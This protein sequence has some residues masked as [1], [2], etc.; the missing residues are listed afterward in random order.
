MSIKNVG[1]NQFWSL[2]GPKRIGIQKLSVQ[3]NI[4]TNVT[5]N[6]T[7]IQVP[8]K[9]GS[10][11]FGSIKFWVKRNLRNNCHQEKFCM[12]KCLCDSSPD[13]LFLGVKSVCQ[14]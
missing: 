4:E 14:N 1:S 7:N 3:K 10:K 13:I 5:R 11:K 8:K 6:K 9:F 2:L 12:R